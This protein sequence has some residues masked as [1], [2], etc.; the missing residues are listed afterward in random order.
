M[1]NRKKYY[2]LETEDELKFYARKSEEVDKRN[3]ETEMYYQ[4][5]R[6]RVLS[7]IRLISGDK[8]GGDYGIDDVIKYITEKY[9][10]RKISVAEFCEHIDKRLK[11]EKYPLSLETDDTVS[12]SLCAGIFLLPTVELTGDLRGDDSVMLVLEEKNGKLSSFWIGYNKV[13]YD[14]LYV[15]LRIFL[16]SSVY[17]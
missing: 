7:D 14:D 9:F 16:I 11:K 17:E 12:D 1:F 13:G 5:N 4:D 15:A 3:E 8:V 2:F 6:D 10:A